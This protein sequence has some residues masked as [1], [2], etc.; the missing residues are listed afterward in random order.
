VEEEQVSTG[1]EK[2]PGTPKTALHAYRRSD[3]ASQSGVDLL[4]R[5]YEGALRSLERARTSLRERD[6][7]G[8][9]ERL[10]HARKIVAELVAGIDPGAGDEVVK[11]LRSLYVF[12][13]ERISMA[14]HEKKEKPV[15][16]AM[17]ILRTLLDGW[18]QVVALPE[19]APL[20]TPAAAARTAVSGTL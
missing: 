15:E 13:I 8:A 5:M 16:D 4:I 18:R 20:R 9:H 3:I 7:V 19:V 1:G 12:V 10:V 11:R 6:P 2:T 17:D 14:N